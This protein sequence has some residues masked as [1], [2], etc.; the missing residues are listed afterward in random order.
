MAFNG[1][2][3][4]VMQGIGSGAKAGAEIAKGQIEDQRKMDVFKQM[5]D[6]EEQKLLRIDEVKRNRDVEDVG[7]KGEAE[8]NVAIARGKNKD[9]L[10]SKSAMDV[11]DVAG[12][13]KLKQTRSADSIASEGPSGGLK[14]TAKAEY[15]LLAK[16]IGAID[17]AIT[18]AQADNTWDPNSDN[19]KTLMDRRAKLANQAM[20]VLK[21]GGTESTTGKSAADFDVS[22]PKTEP[23]S[24]T[25]SRPST[26]PNAAAPS[27]DV[28]TRRV[29]TSQGK[30]GA[31]A[32]LQSKIKQYEDALTANP[33]EG[34][35]YSKQIQGLKDQISAVQRM[36]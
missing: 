16:S 2:L 18:K 30:E 3:Q 24:T 21:G 5:A 11:A 17:N 22:A 31:I 20:S 1:L 14:G 34:L 4:G 7:R 36:K 29:Y 19:A 28:S 27:M 12:D 32:S 23:A 6:I 8:T 26:P 10:A 33:N 9:F 15:D 25:A 35:D 13:I